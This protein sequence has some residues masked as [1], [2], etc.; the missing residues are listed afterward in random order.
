MSCA[1]TW[2]D[3]LH[4]FHLDWGNSQRK[5]D[6]WA[7]S[8]VQRRDLALALGWDGV[9]EEEKISIVLPLFYASYEE[10]QKTGIK[11]MKPVTYDRERPW[12]CSDGEESSETRVC[13]TVR[14]GGNIFSCGETSKNFPAE[15]FWW[16][17]LRWREKRGDISFVKE[18]TGEQ[19][20]VL[21]SCALED[22]RY[23]ISRWWLRLFKI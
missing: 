2:G 14:G 13:R 18:N 17:I 5:G 20:A 22:G 15:L 4:R 16:N 3:Q 1:E 6:N 19:S 11:L 9:K 8:I 10:L 12:L 7:Q 21:W 23:W